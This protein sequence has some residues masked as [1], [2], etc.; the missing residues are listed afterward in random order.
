MPFPDEPLDIRVELQIGGVWT[1]I[2]GDVR[3]RE[4]ITITRGRQDEG[5]AADPG[6]CSLEIRNTNGK[7]SP[8]NPLSPYYGQFGRNTPI[9]VSVPGGYPYLAMPGGAGD[10]LSC[11][12]RASL[13]ITGDIDI[14]I[15]LTPD[16]WRAGSL[17]GKASGSHWSWSLTM[18]ALSGGDLVPILAWTED[19]VTIRSHNPTTAAPPRV[20]T[21]RRALR[22][23]L[24]V[25]NGAGQ[26][27]ATFY[28]ADSIDGPWTVWEVR[29]GT[30]TTSLWSGTAPIEVGDISQ[31]SGD[32][33]P[34]RYHAFEVRS[35]IDGPVVAGWRPDDMTAGSSSFTDPQGNVWTVAGAASISD[36]EY[37]FHGEVSEWPPKWTPGEHD[38]WVPIQAS[39]V[40]RRLG[41]GRKALKGALTRAIAGQTPYAAWWPLEDAAGATQGASGYAGGAPMIATGDAAFGS[42]G[43][44]GVAAGLTVSGTN[45]QAFASVTGSPTEWAVSIVLIPPA[46]WVVDTVSPV[47]RWTTP[48]GTTAVDWSLYV[49]PDPSGSV[50]AVLEIADRNGVIVLNPAPNWVLNNYLTGP[51]MPIHLAVMLNQFGAQVLLLVATNGNEDPLSWAWVDTSAPVTSIYLHTAATDTVDT[52]G[53]VAHVLVGGRTRWGQMLALATAAQGHAGET[54]VERIT[55]VAAEEGIPLDVVGDESEQVGPQGL[56][57]ALDLIAEAASADGGALYER[58][59][60]PGLRY[61]TRVTGYNRP[62]TLTLDYSAGEIAPPLE[63]IDDDQLVRNDVTVE[64]VGGSSARAI[65]ETS[66]LSVLPPPDGVGRYDESLS[67]SLFD[68]S[69][70]ADIAW[71]RVHLG[72]VDEARYPTVA[73]NLHRH[74]HLIPAALATDI[75]DRIRLDG[76]PPYVPPGPTDQIVEGYTETLGL[77]TWRIEFNTSPASPWDVAY[78]DDPMWGRADTDGSQLAAAV[79]AAATTLSVAVTAGP[80]WTTSPAEFPFDVLIGGEVMTVTAISGAASPQTF[81]VVRSVNGISKAH[82]AGTDVRLAHPAIIGL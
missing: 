71:W 16:E 29:T 41:Q 61:R 11:P 72:T 64:R 15:E 14:R 44:G 74:P 31:V 49:F 73:V 8:R 6:S 48:G 57:T 23:T 30:G 51:G 70:L 53:A 13:D 3:T 56:A 21:G 55:R 20:P 7:Y 22:A 46:Q 63:P 68:D 58:L 69:R 38:A 66:P 5:Q 17:V 35:G 62:P 12:D 26:H 34:G 50:I 76:L 78:A 65:D 54:A 60:P 40:L 67:L 75:R 37:R 79:T 4:A 9:R 43:A 32:T 47:I 77:Y 80:L 33:V 45:G 39:G 18:G 42:E 27:V 2:T 28:Y 24:D 19:G 25:D 10:R 52:V 36:R 82:A 81:T 59:D 1:D